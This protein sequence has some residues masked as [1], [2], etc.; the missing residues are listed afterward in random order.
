MASSRSSERPRKKAVVM[1]KLCTIHCWLA[2]VWSRSIRESLVRVGL[3]EQTES[4]SGS[5]K[6][7]TTSRALAFFP[8]S[9]VGSSFQVSI[10]RDDMIRLGCILSRMIACTVLVSSQH[11]S[12]FCL[13]AWN[14]SLSFDVNSPY[15]T[16]FRDLFAAAVRQ[17]RY[18]LGIFRNRESCCFG[19]SKSNETHACSR[20]SLDSQA[21]D[22]S[23]TIISEPATF[24]HME[25]L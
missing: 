8:V 18:S 24:S 25:T 15:F 3:S 20:V 17:G 14:S 9:D 7:F 6:P 22:W 16:S 13:A 5:W 19:I 10:H 1:S 11:C 21:V 12:S 4:M 23:S 2:T